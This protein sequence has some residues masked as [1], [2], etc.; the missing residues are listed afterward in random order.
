MENVRED[1]IGDMKMVLSSLKIWDY[2]V[3]IWKVQRGRGRINREQDTSE[4]I[5]SVIT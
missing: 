3:D 4:L 2:E 1:A 5:E